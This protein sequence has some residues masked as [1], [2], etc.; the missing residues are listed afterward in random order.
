M[1]LIDLSGNS[2]TSL[3]IDPNFIRKLER[4]GSKTIV[5]VED[6]TNRGEYIEHHVNIPIENVKAMVESALKASQLQSEE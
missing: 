4:K 5:I 2:V 6:V 3:L 1:S